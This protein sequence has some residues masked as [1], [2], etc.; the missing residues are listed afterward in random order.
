MIWI[1]SK[2]NWLFFDVEGDQLSKVVENYFILSLR[3]NQYTRL[4]NILFRNQLNTHIRKYY[5]KRMRYVEYVSSLL[6]HMTIL[7]NEYN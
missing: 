6:P 7:E 5:K 4:A 1:I 2:T 3:Y